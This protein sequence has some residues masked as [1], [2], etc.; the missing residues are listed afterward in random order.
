MKSNRHFFLISFLPALAY[1][2]LESN[3]PVRIAVSA[4]VAL[5]LL[6]LLI[7]RIFTGHLHS[8]S[9]FNALLILTLGG[10]ALMD[11]EG[12]WFRLQPLFTGI[13]ISGFL[14][15]RLKC[16]RGLLAEMASDLN[17]HPPPRDL[18]EIMELHLALFLLFYG[19]WMGWVAWKLTVDQWLFFKTAG[20]YLVF[21]VFL[22]GELLYLRFKILKGVRLPPRGGVPS[23]RR[24]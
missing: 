7:E 14:L 1:W 18:L 3:Y 22:V 2:Y 15:Y 12:L 17:K 10:M 16:G 11:D 13:I 5:A 4:G 24:F 20:F 9:K 23:D 6:E 8:L 21:A 19:V